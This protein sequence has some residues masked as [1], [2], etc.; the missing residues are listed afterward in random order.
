MA[1]SRRQ[2]QSGIWHLASGIWHLASAIWNA[3]LN[4]PD[5]WA[6][7]F[8]LPEK[9]PTFVAQ[10]NYEFPVYLADF[11]LSLGSVFPKIDLD[12]RLCQ[13]HLFSRSRHRSRRLFL[14]MARRGM[15][16][17]RL[18]LIGTRGSG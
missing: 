10:R 6:G 12:L 16:C 17:S 2:A 4:R 11:M 3:A 1:K 13:H 5:H 8:D 15:D 18:D 9:F 7:G 14:A